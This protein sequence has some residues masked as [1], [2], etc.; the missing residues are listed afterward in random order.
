MRAALCWF[1]PILNDSCFRERFERA[2]LFDVA[3]ALGGDSDLHGF[4]GLRNEDT[5]LVKVRLA[6][7]LRGRVVLRCT[8]TVRIPSANLRRF[9][10]YCAFACHSFGMVPCD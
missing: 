7:Y 6:T 2:V 3:H 8:G 9:P 1:L 5:A 10:C 4:A